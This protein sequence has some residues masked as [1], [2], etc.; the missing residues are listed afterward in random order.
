MSA[1]PPPGYYRL[2][3]SP[4]TLLE[5]VALG[6]FAL[7]FC[8]ACGQRGLH[9]L[10]QAIV[11]DGAYRILI[12]QEPFRDFILPHSLAVLYLQAAFFTIGG[13]SFYTYVL[14]AA[15]LN[16]VAAF[17]VLRIIALLFP[18]Q[19]AAAICAAALTAVWFFPPFGTPYGEH[20]AFLCGLIG[21]DFLLTATLAYDEAHPYGKRSKLFFSGLFAGLAFYCKQNVAL[22]LWPFFLLTPL[23]A[24]LPEARRYLRALQFVLAGMLVAL[25]FPLLIFVLQGNWQT[26]AYAYLLLPAATAIRRLWAFSDADTNVQAWSL[27]IGMLLIVVMALFSLRRRITSVWAR[28]VDLRT[29]FLSEA[30]ACW[31]GAYVLILSHL[32]RQSMLNNPIIADVYIGL[33]LG[34][35]L[36]LFAHLRTPSPQSRL[37]WAATAIFLVVAGFGIYASWQRKVHESVSD[38]QFPT[39]LSIERLEGLRW[40]DPT[41]IR[42]GNDSAPNREMRVSASDLESLVSFL[43]ADQRNFFIFPDFTFLYAVVG[44]P[45]PQPLLFFHRGL[46]YPEIYQR[47][48]DTW[49]VDSLMAQQVAVVVLEDRSVFGT[50]E[51]LSHFPLLEGFIRSNF[52][53]VQRI[54]PFSILALRTLETE[55][56]A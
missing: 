8:F 56:D 2:F 38:A 18:R 55:G 30:M 39:M 37:K 33:L 49:I 16:V 25:L 10:D 23:L 42:E 21:I 50:G 11:W 19:R 29:R 26:F 4:R 13:V 27:W 5:C 7:L 40:G 12:G 3:H 46:T 24:W 1:I 31:L 34:L 51:R 54:G 47:E 43:K 44:R 36:A 48:V 35:A 28:L 6:V 20:A 53:E 15:V 14:C 17:S 45:P 9:P 32:V 22:F 52:S 41:I